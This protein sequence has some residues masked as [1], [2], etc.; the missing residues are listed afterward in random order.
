MKRKITIG[1][2]VLLVAAGGYF[3]TK[4]MLYV[5]NN[6]AWDIPLKVS[7]TRNDSVVLLIPYRLTVQNNRWKSR[8]LRFISDGNRNKIHSHNLLYNTHG[9][10]LDTYYDPNYKD[11]WNDYF[12]LNYQRTILP[13]MSKTFYYFRPHRLSQKEL[14]HSLARYSREQIDVQLMDL[15]EHFPITLPASLLDSLYEVDKCQPFQLHFDQGS[16]APTIHAI[17]GSHQQRLVNLPDSIRHM[18]TEEAKEWLLEYYRL[19]S[20]RE[21]KIED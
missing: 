4:P 21:T 9:T 20:Q 11:L 17:I 8:K 19:G 13:F 18:D 1:I 12:A 10:A 3:L 15:Y 6:P 7:P 2:I 16:L 14:G 5:A